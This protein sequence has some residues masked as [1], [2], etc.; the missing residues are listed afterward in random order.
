M[1]YNC[2]ICKEEMAVGHSEKGIEDGIYIWCRNEKCPA[3]EVMGHG[4]KE[5]D[6]WEVIQQKYVKKENRE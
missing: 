2:P 3:Q 1:K 6:A 4:F 5:K